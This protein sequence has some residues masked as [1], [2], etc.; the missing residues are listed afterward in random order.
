MINF[1]KKDPIKRIF[2]LS[3]EK[4]FYKFKDEHRQTIICLLSF[5]KNKKYIEETI[6]FFG[7]KEITYEEV[8]EFKKNEKA[9]EII[10]EWIIEEDI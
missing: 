2:K 3:P 10:K 4:F 5:C 9:L 1:F 7:D 8:A 6:A